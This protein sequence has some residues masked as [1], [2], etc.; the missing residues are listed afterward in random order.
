MW[1][2]ETRMVSVKE[3]YVPVNRCLKNR[4]GR[5]IDSEEVSL[6]LSQA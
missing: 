5:M 1:R 2:E 6:T 4:N 3:N